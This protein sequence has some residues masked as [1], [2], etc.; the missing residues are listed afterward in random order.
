MTY[1]T[2]SESPTTGVLFQAKGIASDEI[3]LP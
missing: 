3:E 1:R 2:D